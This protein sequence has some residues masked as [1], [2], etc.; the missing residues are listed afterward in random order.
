MLSYDYDLRELKI[1]EQKLSATI[2]LPKNLVYFDGHFE[3]MPIL[4]G[5]VQIHWAIKLAYK[6]L[7]IEGEFIGVD[8]LKFK[9][10]ISPGY[11][12]NIEACYNPIKGALNFTY[13]S[14]L[15]EHSTGIVKF[16]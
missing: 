16:A 9:K 11:I 8:I 6:N 5:V 2:F 3:N 12:V 13:T 7:K 10:I 4:P 1:E 15:G 14:E